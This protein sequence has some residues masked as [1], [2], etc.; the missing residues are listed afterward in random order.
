MIIFGTRAK[1]LA[2]NELGEI[3]CPSCGQPALTVHILQKYFHLFWIPTFPYKKSVATECAHCK[4][5]L[6]DKEVP[7]PIRQ[8]MAPVM[9]SARTP[10]TMYSGIMVIVALFGI[11]A[12][13]SNVDQQNTKE[14][15]A[16]PAV[17]DIYIVDVHDGFGID[18]AT[19]RYGVLKVT[20]VQG[21][22]V[23]FAVGENGYISAYQAEKAVDK[24]NFRATS[25]FMEDQIILSKAKLREMHQSED[26]DQII[27]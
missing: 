21:D 6:V 2:S 3:P 14:Y 15:L 23:V 18:E 25:A 9:R 16:Q 1:G 27:R 5:A 12:M 10:I 17:D 7:E 26:L 8:E 20:G 19:Y 24:G 13:M 11:G 22:S 4:Q